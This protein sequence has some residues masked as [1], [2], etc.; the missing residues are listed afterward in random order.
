MN[1]KELWLVFSDKNGKELCAYTLRGTFAGE[2]EATIQELSREHKINA[3]DII[4]T[5]KFM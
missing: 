4:V 3:N 1:S 5:E 2:K